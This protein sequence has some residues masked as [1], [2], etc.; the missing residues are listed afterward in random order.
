MTRWIAAAVIGVAALEGVAH[1][2]PPAPEPTTCEHCGCVNSP[3]SNPGIVNIDGDITDGHL[4]GTGIVLTPNGEVL[5]NDHVVHD[6]TNICVSDADQVYPATVAGEDPV[7]DVALIHL[8]GATELTVST[9]GDSS[10]IAVGDE[11][12]T[13]G[14][15]KYATSSSGTI[16]A[17]NLTVPVKYDDGSIQY[18]N[19]IIEGTADVPPGDSGGPLLNKS[20]QV[21]G[22][23]TASSDRTGRGMSI[24]INN[25]L[26]FVK[27]FR[28]GGA[29]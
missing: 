20:G 5:T 26:A 11:V 8:Q 14:N 21:V 27:R 4:S 10:G 25:A 9:L 12:T 17:L 16:T 28:G 23:N 19:G 6:V 29:S 1:T 13:V 3:Q 7:H 24:A 22:V 2:E 18:L 15:N